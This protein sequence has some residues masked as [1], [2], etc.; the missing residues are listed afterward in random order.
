MSDLPNK[1]TKD[2]NVPERG[3]LTP[4]TTAKTRKKSVGK[5]IKETFICADAKVVGRTVFHERIIPSIKNLAYEMIDSFIYGI[6]F[7][8]GQRNRNRVDRD[9]P[10]RKASYTQYSKV[11]S[12]DRK[13]PNKKY[14]INLDEIIFDKYS[15][16]MDPDD[17]NRDEY[18]ARRVLRLLKERAD[19]Y[20]YASV[21]DVYDLIGATS[22]D[23][24]GA[25]YGW[26]SA[27]ELDSS[28]IYSDKDDEGYTIYILSL[29]PPHYV[30]R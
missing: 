19:T 29:A 2:N 18:E 10:Y 20:K 5:K 3:K 25:D 11:S 26:E 6:M 14:G 15:R 9:N 12:S 4:V 13:D 27:E 28:C 21:D 24:I 8:N 30:K 23:W 7:P 1:Y 22:P 16:S 17:K